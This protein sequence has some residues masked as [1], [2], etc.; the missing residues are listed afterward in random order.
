ML[1]FEYPCPECQSTSNLHEEG[2]EY[3]DWPRA[4]IEAA[5]FDIITRIAKTDSVKAK[6]LKQDVNGGNWTALYDDCLSRLEVLHYVVREDGRYRLLGQEERKDE[7][8]EPSVEPIKTVYERGSVNGA[9]DNAVFA[10]I[11]FYEMVDLPWEDTRE[12]V[13]KWLRESG[14]WERGGFAE[15]SP[16]ELVEKKRHVY[17]QGYGWKDKA[18]AAKAVIEQRL[19]AE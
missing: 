3:A 18:E 16:E 11:A 14:A 17:E 2:C 6:Q 10:M 9:H 12:N 5:Y 19:G 7:L 13:V 8:S 1:S 15:R 4:E